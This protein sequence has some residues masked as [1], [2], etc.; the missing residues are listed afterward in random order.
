MPD[1]LTTN[2]GSPVPDNQHS[3]T[4][5][6]RGPTLLGDHHL[7]EK[8][9]HLNRERIPERVVGA[10]GAAAFGTFQPVEDLAQ[11]TKAALF[12]RDR[13]INVAARFSMFTHSRQAP[14]TLRD[15]RGLAVKF[16]TSQGNH[17]LVCGSLPV[18]FIRDAM[19]FADLVHAIKPDPVTT[20]TDPARLFDFLSF[21][22]EATHLLVWLYSDMGIPRSYRHLQAWSQDT[23]VWINARGTAR[24][25]RYQWRPAAGPAYFTAEEAAAMQAKDTNHATRDL[26]DT[27]RAG[28]P[29]QF[30]L[31]V[32]LMLPEE[33]EE[34]AVDALDPTVI[35][36]EQRWPWQRAGR[37]VLTRAPLNDFAES[38]Q[39]AFSPSA[40]VPGIE[41]SNDRLLQGR[42][43]A[44][45]D[46]QRHR[47]GANYLQ[48]SVNR[49]RIGVHNQQQDGL[50][51]SEFASSGVNY[52]PNAAG[53]YLQTGEAPSWTPPID[54]PAV[55]RSA[56]P[57]LD[58]FTQ[59]GESWRSFSGPQRVA[60]IKNLGDELARVQDQRIQST[61]CG[62]LRRADAYL[63][64]AVLRRARGELSDLSAVEAELS[65]PAADDQ[66]SDLE[67]T[68][69]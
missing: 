66:P 58:D 36:P 8:L 5:G 28:S 1:R 53:E 52:E 14:E 61:I 41:L 49:P 34:L 63:G 45:P 35:W 46:A 26:Y 32:Q 48:L 22:P 57:L 43:F 13:N 38:E 20:L 39:L 15:L 2:Q 62:F 47:L 31:L 65:G 24:Y 56:T 12:T 25:V 9:A 4:A 11:Y 16:S 27:L 59:A 69:S 6:S 50:M 30:D 17:D 37:M 60:V 64:D 54:E 29:V 68:A 21:Q 19:K 44:Y 42:A 3:L 67:A 7:L 18:F 33:Q 40:V 51:T 23:Y 10:R 55:T